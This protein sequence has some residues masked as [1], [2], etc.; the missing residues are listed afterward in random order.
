M[1]RKTLS[2]L[3]QRAKPKSLNSEIEWFQVS[4]DGERVFL[5]VHPPDRN[6]WMQEFRWEDVQRI[7]FKAENYM[8]SDGI[9][10]FT[11]NRPESYAIPSEAK[12]GSAFFSEIIRRGLFDAELAIKAASSTDG[13]YCW[14]PLEEGKVS[15]ITCH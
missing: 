10:V 6:P 14:P 12:G 11:S 4:F 1:I 5:A 8:M 9:Y 3:F 13:L 7:C 15:M 2:K